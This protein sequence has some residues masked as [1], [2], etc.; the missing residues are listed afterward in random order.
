MT[1][2]L[3]RASEVVGVS[4]PQR[5]VEL[6]V[7]PYETETLVPHPTENRMITE[8]ISRGAFDGIERRANRVRVNRDHDLQRTVGRAFAFH[9][10]RNEGL[11]AEVKISRTPLGDETLQLAEDGVLDASAGFAPIP[12]DGSRWETRNRWRILRG[13]LGHIAMTPDP[14]Y[15][16]ARVLA[17]R[18][19]ANEDVLAASGELQPTPNLDAV[20]GWLLTDRFEGYS[21]SQH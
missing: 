21:S 8:V 12:P 14:A 3:V 5:T 18:H 11:V 13:F 15:D 10:S 1:D 9:T 4:F 7:I 2:L 17:V 19:G 16:S 6:I 20:R